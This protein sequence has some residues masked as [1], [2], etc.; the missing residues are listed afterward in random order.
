MMGCLSERKMRLKKDVFRVTTG[1]SAVIG[2][3]GDAGVKD[4]GDASFFDQKALLREEAWRDLVLALAV[5]RTSM[6]E[7]VLLRIDRRS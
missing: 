5:T 6:G 1:C 7:A 3:A 2:L 4:D